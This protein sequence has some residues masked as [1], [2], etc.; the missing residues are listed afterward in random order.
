[1]R[2]VIISGGSVSDYARMK[3]QI[4][5]FGADLII[6]ADSGF[7]HALRMKLTVDLIV[8]DFDSLSEIPRDVKTI[9]FP[10][11]KNMTDTEI[12]LAHARESGAREFLFV[13]ATGSRADHTLT[14]ILLLKQCLSRGE[15]AEIIDE[16]NRIRLTETSLELGGEIGDLVSLVPLSDCFG[17]TTAGLEY[18]LSFADLKVGEGLGVSNIIFGEKASVALERGTLAVIMSREN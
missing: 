5:L 9:R 11:R 1:M 15:S 13:G 18:P 10:A 8:G 7:N 4:E 3:K 17:V 2:A 14:N 6:C 12:A 16:H